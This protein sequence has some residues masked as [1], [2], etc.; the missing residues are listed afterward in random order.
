MFVPAPYQ[1]LHTGALH[2]GV[3]VFEGIIAFACK[4][5]RIRFLNPE[6]KALRMRSGAD[7]VLMPQVSSDILV[8]AI[9]DA[10]QQNRVFSPSNIKKG[11]DV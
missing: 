2:Y 7:A 11:L 5:G 4:D 3:S 10:V 1:L 9:K 8:S 6:L